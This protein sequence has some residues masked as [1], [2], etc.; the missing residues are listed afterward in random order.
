MDPPVWLKH[1][2][3]RREKQA[4]WVE[5]AIWDQAVKGPEPFVVRGLEGL[6]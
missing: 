6:L 5:Q 4:V 2:V 3:G 1:H